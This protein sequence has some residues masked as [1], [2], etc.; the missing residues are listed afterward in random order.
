MTS[1]ERDRFRPAYNRLALGVLVS[2]GLL[3]VGCA[4]TATSPAPPSSPATPEASDVPIA[5][6]EE[7]QRPPAPLPERL[8]L[9]IF[10]CGRIEG[11]DPTMFGFP[12]DLRPARDDMFVPCYLIE[13][14]KGRMIFDTGL[15]AAIARAPEGR[16]QNGMTMTLERSLVESLREL[17]DLT[18]A[19]IDF[20]ALSHMHFDHAGQANDFA[21]STWLVQRADYE[22]AFGG[23]PPVAVQPATYSAL[24]QS[25]RVLLDGDHDV[26]GDGSVLL[27][28]TPGHTPGHQA[29]LVRLPKT[30]NLV[31]SGDLYHYPESREHGLVPVFNADRDQTLASMERIEG[32]LEQTGADLWIEHDPALAE[33]LE[34]APYAYR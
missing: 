32:L 24:E 20:L 15:P 13:H 9:S 22:S 31:L 23:A 28:S 17:V 33:S 11:T 27:L 6:V 2:S 12:P 3:L 26:F 18:P 4:T 19:D 16:T 25:E 10:D 7:P 34:L 5:E 30:G 29:L 21:A 14:P 1:H 8:S